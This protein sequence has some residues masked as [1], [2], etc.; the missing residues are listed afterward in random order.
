MIYN[1]WDKQNG[2]IGTSN[3]LKIPTK[4]KSVKVIISGNA[5]S[6]GGKVDFR[7]IIRNADVVADPSKIK[8]FFKQ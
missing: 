4:A 7:S 8:I 6:V 1:Y 2:S 3:T 5:E